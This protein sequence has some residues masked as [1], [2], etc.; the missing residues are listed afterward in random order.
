[1]INCRDEDC[2]FEVIL[3]TSSRYVAS[4]CHSLTNSWS[5]K[6]SLSNS[7]HMCSILPNTFIKHLITILSQDL[8]LC[9]DQILFYTICPKISSKTRMPGKW[10]ARTGR[11]PP[12]S[13]NELGCQ[14]NGG[15]AR[16]ARPPL[17]PP[18]YMVS[19]DWPKVCLPLEF[20]LKENVFTTDYVSAIRFL[21][22]Y[23]F[24]PRFYPTNLPRLSTPAVHP[25][26][27]THC[28][29]KD[30]EHAWPPHSHRNCPLYN[31]W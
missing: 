13:A 12:R 23:C 5:N 20:Y 4:F 8:Q 22:I 17:D 3:W 2:I 19:V 26:T 9:L 15:G 29:P 18:M 16:R 30:M 28:L 11:A 10:G 1:M 7:S 24:P 21:L 31:T 14:A 27:P 25:Q 6:F